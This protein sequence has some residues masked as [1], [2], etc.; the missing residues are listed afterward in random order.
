MENS[1]SRRRKI[2]VLG[3]SGRLASALARIWSR[4]HDVAA[5]TRAECDVSDAAV[6]R[7]SL[8]SR[9]FD[10]LV[11]GTGAPNVDRCE[12]ERDEALRVNA[13]APQ[14]MAE[15]A[16]ARGAR[17]IHF[18]TDYVFD[19]KNK[20]PLSESEPARPCGWY[21]A[22]KLEGENRVLAAGPQHLVVRVSWVFGPGKPSF[23]EW[24]VEKARKEPHVE[25]VADKFSSPTYTE[26]VAGWL[27]PFLAPESPG[28]LFHACNSGSC[29]W[30]E[31]GQKALDFAAEAGVPLLATQVGAVTLADM[32]QFIAERPV[33]SVLDTSKLA[34]A[35][36]RAPRHWHDALREHIRNLYAPLPPSA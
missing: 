36:G 2:L 16:S 18:S 5:L 20:A 1:L 8:S 23:I 24:L 29:S 10:I 4:T 31:Y 11:N 21:G 34:A 12:S 33:H 22:T 6:L 26:D 17:L 28:G 9:E 25:A 35:I 27:E 15:A 30:R 7:E 19:G 13:D 32:K 14:L 3:A